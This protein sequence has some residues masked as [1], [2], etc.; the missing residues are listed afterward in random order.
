MLQMFPV[1]RFPV[2]RKSRPGQTWQ[3]LVICGVVLVVL[4][5]L[6]GPVS[7]WAEGPAGKTR[8][9]APAPGVSLDQLLKLPEGGDYSVERRGTYTQAEWTALFGTVHAALEAQKKNLAIAQARL[10]RV[11]RSQPNWK[12]G[13]SLPGITQSSSDAPLD[14]QLRQRISGIKAEVARLKK[15]L[16]DL[17]VEADLAGVPPEWRS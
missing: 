14:Y 10:D 1:R 15:V 2:F 6:W 4:V 13:L 17:E 9:S 3:H 12:V 8:A 5:G 7:A 11:A 16:K